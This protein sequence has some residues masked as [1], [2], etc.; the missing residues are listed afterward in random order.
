VAKKK[1]ITEKCVVCQVD[2]GVPVNTHVAY[3]DLY[4]EGCGQLCY[5]C[6]KLIYKK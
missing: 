5:K 3:R 2:T 6:W 4:V 1:V